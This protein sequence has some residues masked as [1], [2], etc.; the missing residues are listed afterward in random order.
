M[1]E[2]ELLS[3]VIASNAAATTRRGGANCS[4]VPMGYVILPTGEV[5]FDPD[6]QA[7]FVVK[8]VFDKFEELGS[9][10]GMCSLAD[11][12]RHPASDPTQG[13]AE[14]G[15]LEWRR[16]S[17]PTL[18]QVL[19]HPIYAGAYAVRSAARRPNGR[20]TPGHRYRPWVPMEQWK[21]L[22]KDRLPAYISWM[23]QP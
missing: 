23:L 21:V 4:S 9:I 15:Q 7:R 2:M 13:R 5:D 6:E 12:T 20:S 14:K 11:P 3:C 19:R 16:P 10:Y 18:A 17:I 8:L 1:S 22:I